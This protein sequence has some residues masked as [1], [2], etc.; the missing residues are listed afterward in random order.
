MPQRPIIDADKAIGPCDMSYDGKLAG[1]EAAER[2]AR[3]GG[4]DAFPMPSQ[5]MSLPSESSPV[6]L[7]READK[8]LQA[9]LDSLH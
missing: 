6:D 1:F 7:E 9:A 3:V 2:H 8:F 5:H 4:Y